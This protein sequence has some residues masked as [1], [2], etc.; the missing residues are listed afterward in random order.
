MNHYQTLGITTEEYEALQEAFQ[1][2]DIKKQGYISTDQFSHILVSLGI[3][4]QQQQIVHI[5]ESADINHDYKIDFHEFVLAMYRFLPHRQ[6]EEEEEEQD[7]SFNII[8]EKSV[9]DE[10]VMTWFR[11]FDQD[12]DGRISQKELEQVMQRFD[13]YL[14]PHEMK[15]MMRTADINRDGF[16]DFEEFKQ[17]LPPL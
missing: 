11:F 12:H 4:N 1:L 7:S 10:E 14:T 3:V 6:E 9:S 17:L 2:Y 13:I 8:S 15:D 5:I 16:V